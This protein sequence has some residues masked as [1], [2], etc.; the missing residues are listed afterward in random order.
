MRVP[1]ATLEDCM[2]VKQVVICALKAALV[3]AAA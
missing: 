1:F 2:P 3:A